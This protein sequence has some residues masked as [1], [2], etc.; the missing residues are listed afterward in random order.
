MPLAQVPADGRRAATVADVARAAGVSAMTVSRVINGPEKVASA[1]RERV[2]AAMATLD[3]RPNQMARGLASGRSHSIGVLTVDTALYGPRAAL[4]GIEKAASARGYSVTIT[5]LT[6]V[7]REAVERGVGLLRSRAADGVIL[8]QPLMSHAAVFPG[9]GGLPM[10]AI[11]AGNPDKYPLVTVDNSLGA[12]LATEHLL[13]LGHRTVWHIAGP[14]DW[15]ESAERVRGWRE[16]LA[17]VGAPDNPITHGD[18]SAASGYAA[19]K[20]LLGAE[21]DVTAVFV[22]NDAMALGALHAIN[23]LGLRCPDDISVV[24]FDDYPEAEFFSPGLT[25][26]RQDFDELGRLS[27]GLL[28]DEIESGASTAEHVTLDPSLVVRQSTAAPRR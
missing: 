20:Q 14:L 6:D 16:A 17:D 15:Y 8:L 1:T 25:T 12:R 4:A 26:I 28:L 18:W 3:Y 27:L 7:D 13:G 10:V 24:G 11:H 19:T 5:H 23:E 2:E 9:S 21:P 22:A